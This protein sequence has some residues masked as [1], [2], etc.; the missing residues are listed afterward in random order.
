MVDTVKAYDD[1]ASSFASD[2]LKW[3]PTGLINKFSSLLPKGARVLDEGC[4]SGR[5]SEAL[6][7]KGFDVVGLDASRKVVEFAKSKFPKISFVK[8]DIR[9]L[10]F[11]GESFHGVWSHAVLLHMETP[12]D[13]K[14]SLS[15]A[16]R[17]LKHNGVLHLFTKMYLGGKKTEVLKSYFF[18]EPRYFRYFKIEELSN[19]I[20]GA[21]FS[22]LEIEKLEESDVNNGGRCGVFWLHALASKI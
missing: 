22:N 1:V 3:V 4:G 13:V 10:P 12:R 14:K 17:V 21:G 18:K 15:E 8:G 19:L 6:Y 5:D 9:D 16:Y 20:I 2:S 11:T 7:K